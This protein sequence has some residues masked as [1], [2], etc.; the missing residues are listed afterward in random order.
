MTRRRPLADGVPSAEDLRSAAAV[1]AH[2]LQP[3]PTERNEALSRRYA[4]EVYVKLENC[5]PIRSFKVRGALA[6]LAT[7][8]TGD[9]D[10]GVVTASTGNHGQGI[11]Y[12]ARSF[13]MRAVIAVPN[14]TDPVKVRAMEYLGAR[15]LEGGESLA[16]CES[17]AQLHG[18]ATGARY[19][20]DGDDRWLMAGAATVVGELLAAAPDVDTIVVPVGGGNLAAASLLAVDLAGHRA[21]VV[22]VQSSAATATT[23]SWLEG[24]MLTL[25]CATFA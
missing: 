14:D 4:R 15:L 7:F 23:R 22:G 12:A 9:R 13:G 8:E 16:E 6:A 19:I 10:R 18:K 20:E 24:R 2:R 5:S 1:V 3:T 25:P 17:V 11:A 21:T